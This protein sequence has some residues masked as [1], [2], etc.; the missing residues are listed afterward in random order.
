MPIYIGASLNHQ[1]MFLYQVMDTKH[2]KALFNDKSLVQQIVNR[3]KKLILLDLKHAKHSLTFNVIC[4]VPLHAVHLN[5][6]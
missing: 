6:H 3:L 2:V 1:Y 4:A 5:L